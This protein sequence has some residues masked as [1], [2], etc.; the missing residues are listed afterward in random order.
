MN[1][2]PL[3][4][5]WI[6]LAGTAWGARPA[7]VELSNV[8]TL[9]AQ[10][11]PKVMVLN[12]DQIWVEVLGGKPGES[13]IPLAN[14]SGQTR[15]PI[16]A[17][18]SGYFEFGLG[19]IEG[20]TGGDEAQ[21][22]VKAWA[23]APS[24]SE[25]AWAVETPVWQQKTG[26]GP[27]PESLILPMP[28]PL[29]LP[30]FE[31]VRMQD[32]MPPGD[33][34][35]LDSTV[36]GHGRFPGTAALSANGRILA[37]AAH[38][39]SVKLWLAAD[40]LYWK[41]LPTPLRQVH[42]L[43]LSPDGTRLVTGDEIGQI[44]LWRVGTSELLRSWPGHSNRVTS[45]SA[46][47]QGNLFAT[48][49]W[50]GTLRF[51]TWDGAEYSTPL[52]ADDS[53]RQ[54]FQ[55]S[56]DGK[57]IAFSGNS[58]QVRIWQIADGTLLQTVDATGHALEFS[59]DSRLLAV[60]DA[61]EVTVFN[62]SQGDPV[63]SWDFGATALAF[64]PA[65]KGLAIAGKSP[66]EP[67]TF[68]SLPEGDLVWTKHQDVRDIILLEFLPGGDRFI[69]I[70]SALG[71]AFYRGSR[72][73]HSIQYWQTGNDRPPPPMTWNTDVSILSM[74][75][76]PDGTVMALGGYDQIQLRQRNG[77]TLTQSFSGQW[78]G[79]NDLAF[80]PDGTILASSSFEAGLQ[81][82]ELPSGD[83]LWN[84]TPDSTFTSSV[85]FSPDAT[86][87]ALGLHNHTI[88]IYRLS[89]GELFR[90]WK[91]EAPI[92]SL[93]FNANSDHLAAGHRDGTVRVWRIG[94]GQL[95]LLPQLAK[96]PLVLERIPLGLQAE[97]VDV[98]CHGRTR[99]VQRPPL[100]GTSRA[101]GRIRR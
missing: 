31:F 44:R 48:A 62:V 43:A 75:I 5:L 13:L 52:P 9:K 34:M 35:T 1:R 33:P 24:F 82:W 65:G 19:T 57:R 21:F 16:P 15:F 99:T 67:V 66:Q 63:Q 84:F 68:W 81:V 79:V 18:Y 3:I 23:D 80:S 20:L 28:E 36:G 7:L 85:S 86:L 27:P 8:G 38:D 42:S 72:S 76:S 92:R 64:S 39:L 12:S 71:R 73:I 88:Q 25:A 26:I 74:S 6:F 14:R 83:S 17:S 56:P 11:I 46:S 55:F 29:R 70:G 10:P 97:P 45:I 41:K 49:S 100:G 96:Q 30:P 90:S 93:A 91:S 78:G 54:T 61:H 87:L 77:H 58:D 95:L 37:T 101:D 47:P 22:Q 69:S 60:G 32:F 98:S 89:H 51:W 2:S 59:P 40:R 94:D 53:A 4:L 50:D